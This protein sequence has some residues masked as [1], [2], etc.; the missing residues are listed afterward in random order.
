MIVLDTHISMSLTDA[1][2]VRMTELYSDCPVLTLDSD[3]SI[4]RKNRDRAIATITP[5]TP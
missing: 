2:L 5:P 1:C 4:Y 3:F